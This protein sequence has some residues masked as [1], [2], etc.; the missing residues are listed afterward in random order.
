M[1]LS[2][3]F[4]QQ[5]SELRLY[6]L[7]DLD[8]FRKVDGTA[9]S[10]LKICMP[11]GNGDI[12]TQISTDIGYPGFSSLHDLQSVITD[13]LTYDATTAS[14]TLTD[15]RSL[16]IQFIGSYLIGV[17]SDLSDNSYLETFSD[18]T[19]QTCDGAT[20]LQDSYLPSTSQ[21]PEYVSCKV[22]DGV[23]CNI[24]NYAANACG[25]CIDLSLLFAPPAFTYSPGSI[26]AAVNTRYAPQTTCTV[27]GTSWKI[28]GSAIS[29]PSTRTYTPFIQMSLLEVMLWKLQRTTL[30]T[31]EGTSPT[32]QRL[33][34]L[35][36]LVYLP[37]SP[38]LTQ[39]T[40]SSED[41]TAKFWAKTS[42]ESST[43]CVETCTVVFGPIDW[44]LVFLVSGC[45]SVLLYSLFRL[46]ALQ[47]ID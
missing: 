12:L 16:A 15:A 46:P 19:T 3:R 25:G 42:K 37:C 35:P 31:L 7:I 26:V 30:S 17:K 34:A 28:C 24:G 23:D 44:Q 22:T 10:Y 11:F 6:F 41:L 18:P 39:S 38:F 8:N 40:G 2:K 27:F 21:D 45:S 36:I 29:S 5:L 33:S 20:F 32:L 9:V 14:N 4:N 1:R 13:F 43:V 47:A